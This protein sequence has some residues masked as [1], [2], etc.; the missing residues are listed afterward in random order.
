MSARPP[1]VYVRQLH[2]FPRGGLHRS[3]EVFDLRP[4]LF[5]GSDDLERQQMAVGVHRH[6]DLA[7]F[8]SLG[9]IVAGAASALRGRLEGPAVQ[10]GRAGPPSRP[11]PTRNNRRRFAA[12][13]SKQP[14]STQRRTCC[15]TAGHGGRSWGSIRHGQPART[16]HRRPLKCSL[17]GCSRCGA[18]SF[19]KVRYGAQNAPLPRTCPP[20]SAISSKSYASASGIAR[21]EIP[22][23]GGHRAGLLELSWRQRSLPAPQKRT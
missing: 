1:L 17:S 13:C 22:S 20:I 21:R 8:A 3:G 9:P 14:A 12:M 2:V 15:C 16:N 23:L 4:V 10:D 7:A 19:I 5:A 11:S 18:S 6:M